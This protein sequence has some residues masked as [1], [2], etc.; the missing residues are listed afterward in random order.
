M[1]IVAADIGGTNARFALAEIDAGRVVSV[2]SQA[3]SKTAAH[4]SLQTAWKAFA[5]QVGRPLPRRAAIAIAAPLH[6]DLLKLTNSPWVIRISDLK[7]Q[8]GLDELV[9]LN[10]F[11]AMAHA[12]AQLDED[13]LRHVCGSDAPLPSEGVIS[14][15]GPGTGLGVAQL[16]RR[17]GG[18]EVLSTEGGHV[19]FAPFDE[20]EDRILHHLRRRYPRVSAERVVSGPG[21][22]NIYE[23][24]AAI[25]GVAPLFNDDRALWSAALSE[26]D[27]LAEAALERF[28]LCFGVLAGD[29]ALAHGAGAVAIASGLSLKLADRL[30]RS[31]FSQRFAA[32][33]RFESMMQSMPVRRVTHPQPGLYGAAAA[34]LHERAQGI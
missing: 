23:A 25:E 34:F 28:C 10:D 30:G 3:V 17:A 2:A 27:S 24:L 31:G 7:R 18:Y 14:V 20:I 16:V 26:E 9:L 13:R 29:I 32:K 22:L 21:L 19:S 33:G 6:E 8:L 5:A 15:I 12:V 4:A 1:E 11:A